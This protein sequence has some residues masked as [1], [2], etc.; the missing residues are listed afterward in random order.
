MQKMILLPVWFSYIQTSEQAEKY[1]IFKQIET[2]K[3]DQFKDLIKD[4][5]SLITRKKEIRD[6]S[7]P[8][9][10]K[11]RNLEQIIKLLEPATS[12]TST[13]IRLSNYWPN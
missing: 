12:P 10:E 8:N 13:M 2:I 7:Y 11:I 4:V 9:L 1:S 6:S 5:P 3:L